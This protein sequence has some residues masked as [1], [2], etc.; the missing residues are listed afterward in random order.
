MNVLVDRINR[1]PKPVKI[2]SLLLCILYVAY[3]VITF[4]HTLFE[5]P[6]RTHILF[7]YVVTCVSLVVGGFFTA[8]SCLT[9]YA[10]GKTM[11]DGVENIYDKYFQ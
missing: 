10:I 7:Q 5:F 2:W 1:I 3:V 6:Y 8:L 9:L 4:T 11:Y